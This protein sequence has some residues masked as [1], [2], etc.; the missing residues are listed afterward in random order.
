MKIDELLKRIIDT[1]NYNEMNVDTDM[2]IEYACQLALPLAQKDV[3]AVTDGVIFPLMNQYRETNDNDE[4]EY[5]Q[6]TVEMVLEF[7]RNNND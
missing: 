4:I 7:M 3:K 2:A 1:C 6:D 5:I